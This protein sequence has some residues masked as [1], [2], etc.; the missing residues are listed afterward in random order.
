M[1]TFARQKSVAE[2]PRG[3][4]AWSRSGELSTLGFS[5]FQGYHHGGYHCA[6]KKTSSLSAPR[7]SQNCN[8]KIENTDDE[9]E[10]RAFVELQAALQQE[11]RSWPRS[12]N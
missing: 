4:A 7:A 10:E 6:G 1:M 5:G 12:R 11:P 3:D 9:R 2:D 8:D